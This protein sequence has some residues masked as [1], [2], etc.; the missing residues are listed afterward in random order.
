MQ[1]ATSLNAILI[2]SNYKVEQV[3]LIEQIEN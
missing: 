1:V 2:I 3:T